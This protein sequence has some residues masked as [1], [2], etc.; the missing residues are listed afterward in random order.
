MAVALYNRSNSFSPYTGAIGTRGGMSA[1]SSDGYSYTPAT[2]QAGGFYYSPTGEDIRGYDTDKY[3][4]PQEAFLDSTSGFSSG[5]NAI[6]KQ[7]NLDPKVVAN[8]LSQ[9][10]PD[11]LQWMGS[12]AA[13]LRLA[14]QYDPSIS[15]AAEQYIAQN[16]QQFQGGQQTT[17]D[18]WASGQ[19]PQSMHSND[20]ADIAKG[21][22][23]VASMGVAGGALAGAE[24]AG[25]GAG[26]AG[27]GEGAVG[28]AA[29]GF[30][31]AGA[32][33]GGAGLAGLGGAAAAGAS[34][35]LGGGSV[36]AGL[37][38]AASAG[39]A[40]SGGNFLSQGNSV[41]GATN[42]YEGV[43]DALANPSGA[44]NTAATGPLA[45]GA[46][47]NIANGGSLGD[48]LTQLMSGSGSGGINTPFG[49]YGLKDL[50]GAGFNYLNQANTANKLNDTA[51]QAGAM[52][53][54]AN[55]P[56][57]V[58]MQQQYLN[59]LNNPSAYVNGIGAPMLAAITQGI[60]PSI[61][62]S[63]NYGAVMGDAA[64]QAAGVIAGNYNGFL[65]NLG[66]QTGLNQGT[67]GAGQVYGTLAG[68]SALLQNSAYSGLGTL[69]S[70][71]NF[72]G[73]GG[74]GGGNPPL[75]NSVFGTDSI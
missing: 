51:N 4:S 39:A 66:S 13:L 36:G 28:G 59:Y 60:P 46:A 35:G 14:A 69:L 9:A 57:S 23:F 40:G 33:G 16:P 64:K 65:S 17:A 30:A 52:S 49:N 72:G 29:G 20:Y 42:P 41:A 15:Q 25:G 56:A 62:K 11:E 48:T 38:E 43:M 37:G 71:L 54:P 53:D 27:L 8:A 10:R 68:Q 1:D 32:A 61:A 19:R 50:L 63:G 26:L 3:G 67:G 34:G 22:A 70:K 24:A 18:L 44:G 5:L 55:R 58:T 74:S 75:N 73:S 47:G 31:G 2:A 45:N 21:I 12:P 7:L 6:V